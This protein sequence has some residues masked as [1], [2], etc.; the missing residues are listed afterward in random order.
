MVS[1]AIHRQVLLTCE[2][3]AISVIAQVCWFAQALADG[4]NIINLCASLASVR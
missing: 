3:T 2:L 1:V 4:M